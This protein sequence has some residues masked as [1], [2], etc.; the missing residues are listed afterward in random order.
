MRV[1]TR[2]S[3]CNDRRRQG[4]GAQQSCSSTRSSTSLSRCRGRNP[5]SQNA[6]SKP[7][8]LTVG[9]SRRSW[10]FHPEDPGGSSGRRIQKDV[11]VSQFFSTQSRWSMT[12]LRP[13]KTE[14]MP[15][16]QFIQKLVEV[17][18]IMQ[19]SSGSPGTTQ[20]SGDASDSD[21][22]SGN[23]S[24]ETTQVQFKE[25][26]VQHRDRGRTSR[27]SRRLLRSHTV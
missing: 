1:E 5:V 20:N 7:Q 6:F 11:E 26:N 2:Q 9:G 24:D 19:S 23:S 21:S 22:G 14:Q 4:S 12:L 15:L 16:V 8:R 27:R 17:T 25:M 3:W 18:M 10:R 13:Q